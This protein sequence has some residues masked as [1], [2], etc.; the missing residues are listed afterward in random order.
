MDDD[1]DDSWMASANPRPRRNRTAAKDT[2][3]QRLVR[4]PPH[5]R[6][7]ARQYATRDTLPAA[8]HSG[9]I[10][11]RPSQEKRRRTKTVNSRLATLPTKLIR[12]RVRRLTMP[13]DPPRTTYLFG[14]SMAIDT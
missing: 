8:D 13:P 4:M 6:S 7:Y 3:R 5:S 11:S 10:E 9:R 2:R 1:S 12:A 14:R